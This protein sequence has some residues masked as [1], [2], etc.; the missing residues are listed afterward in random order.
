MATILQ[1]ESVARRADEPVERVRYVDETG[2][3]PNDIGENL[4]GSYLRYV[5][6]C[7][8][9]VHNTQLDEE[10]GEID[11]IGMRLATKEVIFC[12]VTTHILGMQYGTYDST[13]AK[14]RAKI[15]RASKFAKTMFPTDRRRYEIWSPV[16][17]K[18]KLTAR[19]AELEH[20]YTDGDL[21]VQ[22]VINDE[23]ANRIQALIDD[24]R[25]NSKAT[26]DPAY[27]LLQILTRLKGDI[28]L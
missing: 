11:V 6:R 4:V 25:S 21:D 13:V 27:R 17:P 7:D 19:F 18:G 16:V 14:V 2:G 5:E 1:Q 12:E 9:V 3:V 10:Q 8:F 24:A 23:Y 20:A 28:Q 22:F 26:S 15:E